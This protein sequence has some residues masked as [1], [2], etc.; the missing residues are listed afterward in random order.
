MAKFIRSKVSSPEVY[1]LM[2]SAMLV[3]QRV[4]RR[5]DE[6]DLRLLARVPEHPGELILDIG[7]NGGQSAMALSFLRP[8]AQ[9]LSYEP[10]PMLWPELRRVRRFI[11]K[12]FDFRGY[13]L[14]TSQANATIYVP[15][16]G[17]L[18]ISTRASLLEEEAQSQCAQLAN[19]TGLETSISQVEIEIRKGDDEGLAPVAIKLDVEGAERLVLDGL[20]ETIDAHRPVLLIEYSES[21]EDCCAFFSQRDYR[22]VVGEDRGDGTFHCPELSN[23]NWIAAPNEHAHL[24]AA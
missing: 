17:R 3:W 22:I 18:P 14:G 4:L 11:G 6:P 10:L 20:A 13:G 16:A 1:G 5:P 2:R 24:F 9:I 21:F 12:R 19:E 23:R 15:V 7:A 8:H